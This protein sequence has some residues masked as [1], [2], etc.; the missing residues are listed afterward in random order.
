[1]TA[2]A[3]SR[4]PVKIGLPRLPVAQPTVSVPSMPACL[5]PSTGQ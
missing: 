4:T 1:M 5:W 2:G 3:R